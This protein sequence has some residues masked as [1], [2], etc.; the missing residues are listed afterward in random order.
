MWLL[1]RR[2][3]SGV[4]I[5]NNAQ[6]SYCAGLWP[7][8]SGHNPASPSVPLHALFDHV[9]CRVARFISP[10]T[11]IAMANQGCTNQPATYTYA[12]TILSLPHQAL[13]PTHWPAFHLVPEFRRACGINLASKRSDS[14]SARACACATHVHLMCVCWQWK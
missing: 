5:I 4:P 9:D 11:G 2:H 7:P 12:I 3:V 6:L 8:A 13:Q 1:Q 10:P 14:G